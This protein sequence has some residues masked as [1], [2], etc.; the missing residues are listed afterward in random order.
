MNKLFIIGNGFDLSHGLRTSYEDFHAYLNAKYPNARTSSYE[1]EIA[2]YANDQKFP[3]E[4]NES[5]GF[6]EQVLSG[7]YGTKWSDLEYAIGHINY[8]NSILDYYDGL[9]S[10]EWQMYFFGENAIFL[11]Y[12]I[13]QI[14]GFF[15]NGF[16]R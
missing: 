5:V 12:P 7:M 8:R 2:S 14:P 4:G 16:Q 1:S 15:Q 3:L 11:M 13:L 9:D 10:E 6:I